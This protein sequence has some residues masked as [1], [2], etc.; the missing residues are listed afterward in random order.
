MSIRSRIILL[1]ATSAAVLLLVLGAIGIG[2][3][4][5]RFKELERRDARLQGER[6]E[7]LIAAEAKLSGFLLWENFRGWG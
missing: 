6:L 2:L 4:Q 7:E 3:V 1:I 5:E